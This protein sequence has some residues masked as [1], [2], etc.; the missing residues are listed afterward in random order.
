MKLDNEIVIDW[1]PHMMR[2]VGP[3]AKMLVFGTKYGM[4]VVTNR[5]FLFLS[6]GESGLWGRL[7]VCASCVCERAP[8]SVGIFRTGRTQWKHLG[9]GMRV[10]GKR[11]AVGRVQV[12]EVGGA[13]AMERKRMRRLSL[14]EAAGGIE[15]CGSARQG[16]GW[17]EAVQFSRRGRCAL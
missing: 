14:L 3:R 12:R 13:C 2:Y 9:E 16:V 8:R 4:V 5:R 11:A 1:E 7:G 15:P 10:T 17:S 6:E